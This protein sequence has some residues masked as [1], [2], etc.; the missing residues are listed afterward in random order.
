[1]PGQRLAL[2]AERLGP[3]RTPS[4]PPCYALHVIKTT[5]AAHHFASML[6]WATV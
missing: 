5:H 2:L 1:M 4:T 6:H 3:T